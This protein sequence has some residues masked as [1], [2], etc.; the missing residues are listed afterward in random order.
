MSNLKLK[1]LIADR[2][3]H[4]KI[5]ISKFLEGL[6][7]DVRTCSSEKEALS[8]VLNERIHLA[9]LDCVLHPGDGLE[10]AK[11]IR[12]VLGKSLDII[13]MSQL[14]DGSV[15]QDYEHLKILGF[16]KKPLKEHELETYIKQISDKMLYGEASS[17]LSQILNQSLSDN[18]KIKI[19]F[20]TP[21]LEGHQ[22]M[23]LL[24]EL[25]HAKESVQLRFSFD[26]QKF[27]LL[28]LDKG[29]IV[30]YQPDCL[31]SFVQKL[32][33]EG[34]LTKEEKNS[35]S[36]FDFKTLTN[37]LL[38]EG[39]ISPHQLEEIA[40]KSFLRVL[41]NLF[42]KKVYFKCKLIS[43]VERS[44]SIPCE[45]FSELVFKKINSDGI[46]TFKQDVEKHIKHEK[47]KLTHFKKTSWDEV[48]KLASSVKSDSCINELKTQLSMKDFQFYKACLYLILKGN[49]SLNTKDVDQ[50]N[51]KERYTYMLK[52][53]ESLSAK[54]CFEVLYGK[55]LNSNAGDLF[56][57]IYRSFIRFNHSDRISQDLPKEVYD[58]LNQVILK[59]KDYENALLENNG[60]AAKGQQQAERIEAAIQVQK[61]KG[62]MQKLLEDEKYDKC[63]KLMSD[64][65]PTQIL[66]DNVLQLLYLWLSFKRP[67]LA[68]N[69]E[70]R[71]KILS[72][73]NSIGQSLKRSV[74]FF[75]VM[76]LFYLSKQDEDKALN[77]FNRCKTLDLSFSPAHK[78]LRGLHIKIARRDHEKSSVLQKFFSKIN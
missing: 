3:E 4:T 34:L 28:F 51:I 70:V 36:Y 18:E 25:L 22:F 8:I 55:P 59:I 65:S 77:F 74:V 49:L 69:E 61:L 27:H 46:F 73:L 71:Q 43:E 1:V 7:F 9:I 53:V 35:L 76:G 20:S 72:S 67:N 16:M 52:F 33:D 5:R 30:N 41:R 44:F 42:S 32:L 24:S 54:E 37:N 6:G 26:N 58:T 40:Y 2:E 60:E 12:D 19:L 45:K 75:Y 38:V 13:M 15:L 11:K 17:F 62:M 50:E 23:I 64:I 10:L 48:D 78:E 56:K 31:K 63:F 39:L 68:F 21:H 47:L 66:E 57:Q 14:V 29:K